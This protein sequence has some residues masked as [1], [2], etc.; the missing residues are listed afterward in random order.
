MRRLP[1]NPST[2]PWNTK[3]RRDEPLAVFYPKTD[4]EE[5]R[6]PA[7]AWKNLSRAGTTNSLGPEWLFGPTN[8][9]CDGV[10]RG[11]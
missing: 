9:D 4:G 5:K 1:P 8:T 7:G 11:L 10:F 3:R 6:S 2:R